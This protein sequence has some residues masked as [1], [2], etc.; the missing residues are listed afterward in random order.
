LI[1]DAGDVSS[2]KLA[3]K[4]RGQTGYGKAFIENRTAGLEPETAELFNLTRDLADKTVQPI[5]SSQTAENSAIERLGAAVGEA[6]Q[7]NLAPI[8]ATVGF[9]MGFNAIA[10]SPGAANTFGGLMV[11][12]PKLSGRV[13]GEAGGSV[14]DALLIQNIENDNR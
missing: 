5:G 8:A 9:P 1:D 12:A 14:L 7:G 13:G 6:T 10:K 3:T 11:P 4:L 2:R